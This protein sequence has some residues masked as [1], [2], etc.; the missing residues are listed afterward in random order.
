MKKGII[1]VFIL[2]FAISTYAI[3]IK[4]ISYSIKIN[5]QNDY[6]SAEE[7]K[8]VEGKAAREDITQTYDYVINLMSFKD[9]KL[10]SKNFSLPIYWDDSDETLNNGSFDL[11]LPYYTNAKK[12]EIY[13]GNKK[14]SEKDISG[15][16]SCNQDGFCSA[17]EILKDCPEDCTV[18]TAEPV[19]LPTVTEEA[20]PAATEQKDYLTIAIIFLLILVIA[21]LI[22]LANKKRGKE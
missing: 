11:F 1:T 4:E 15:L 9:E 2:I 21:L 14:I 10:S 6:A 8:I 18:E 7:V 20:K 17:L 16:S 3:E 5:F 13:K 22:H 12:V 19:V